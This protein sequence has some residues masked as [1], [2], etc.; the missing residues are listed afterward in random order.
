M[1]KIDSQ[2]MN[3]NIIT[4]LKSDQY[5]QTSEKDTFY[6]YADDLV[7]SIPDITEEEKEISNSLL[8]I[9]GSSKN[10][11]EEIV[12]VITPSHLFNLSIH[13]Q[14]ILKSKKSN[15]FN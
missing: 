8:S 7:I 5:F 2:E 9:I 4:C 11:E 13:F 10:D 6:V 1:L 15:N 14:R 12:L 3:K